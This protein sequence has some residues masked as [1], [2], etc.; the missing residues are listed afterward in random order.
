MHHTARSVNPTYRE[1]ESA[2]KRFKSWIQSRVTRKPDSTP[3]WDSNVH[4]IWH[5]S[6]TQ[7]PTIRVPNQPHNNHNN[8]KLNTY[9]IFKALTQ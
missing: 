9:F 3:V 1:R 4:P 5:L 7:T 8:K 2:W 6:G